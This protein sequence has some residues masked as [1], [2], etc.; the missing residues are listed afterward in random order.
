MVCKNSFFAGLKF[1]DKEIFLNGTLLARQMYI[2]GIDAKKR[3]K[4]NIMAGN[5][6]KT[7]E[8]VNRKA[9][10]EYHFIDVYEAVIVLQGTEIKSIRKGNANLSDAYCVFQKGELFVRS[11]FIAEYEH[12]TYANHESR[13][14]RK[15]LLRSGELRK[16]ERKV[17]ERGF[18]IVPYKLYLSERG[19]AKLE[20]ALAQ[21]KKTHDKRDSIKEKDNKREMDRMK[22]VRI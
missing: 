13:R 22:K 14:I 20:I 5:K 21:G 17:K 8:I 18:T 2:F 16:L 9:Q 19:M 15:L 7:I 10:Y 11:M 3:K 6:P 4:E 12:G 1:M